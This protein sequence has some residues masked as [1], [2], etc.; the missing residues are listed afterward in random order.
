M[1]AGCWAVFFEELTRI[2]KLKNSPWKK[3]TNDE[4]STVTQKQR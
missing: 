1:K 4:K 2:L 3:T